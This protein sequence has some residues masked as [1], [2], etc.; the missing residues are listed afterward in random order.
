MDGLIGLILRE[1]D[2]IVAT[3]TLPPPRALRARPTNILLNLDAVA[4]TRARAAVQTRE[5]ADT[6][7][8]THGPTVASAIDSNS[9]AARQMDQ[10]PGRSCGRRK[11]RAVLHDHH[12]LLNQPRKD[13]GL[14]P[15]R[16]RPSIPARTPASAAPRQKHLNGEVFCTIVGGEITPPCGVPA[17][18][19][20]HRA[21]LHDPSVQPLPQ[22]LQHPPVRDTPRHFR[23]RAIHGR[24]CRKTP[25]HTP[26]IHDLPPKLRIVRKRHPCEGQLLDVVGGAHRRGILV[27][28]L[29]LPD[30]TRSLIPAAWTDLADYGARSGRRQRHNLP[31]QPWGR[32]AI[33][34]MPGRSWMLC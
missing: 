13:V 32:F 21:V 22:Q 31:A 1:L 8:D 3:V 25:P 14:T 18:L 30:G 7:A 11:D 26:R 27:L 33:C 34:C 23:H 28:T 12:L 19:V 20:R 15:L 16:A 6:P 9:H 17:T 24:C 5:A 4:W 29:V 2:D 10:A